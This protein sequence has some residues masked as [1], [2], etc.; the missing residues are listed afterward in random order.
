LSGLVRQ[1]NRELR[2]LNVEDESSLRAT[3]EALAI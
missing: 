2:C 3:R 1:I